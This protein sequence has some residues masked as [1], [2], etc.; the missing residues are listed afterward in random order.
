MEGLTKS[1]MEGLMSSKITGFVVDAPAP[2]TTLQAS[3]WL[4]DHV[5]RRSLVR[6]QAGGDPGRWRTRPARRRS[7][8]EAIVTQ[9]AGSDRDVGR[10]LAI[11]TA[12]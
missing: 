1:E 6:D 3:W 11:Q 10:R 2:A 7:E 5:Q 9:A 12:C 8:A 4:L